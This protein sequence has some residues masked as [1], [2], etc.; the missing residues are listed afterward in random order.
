M[1]KILYFYS[2]EHCL[3][4]VIKFQGTLNSF[5]F[6]FLS[7]RNILIIICHILTVFANAAICKESKKLAGVCNQISLFRFFPRF[8]DS[9]W[10]TFCCW[11]FY[12]HDVAIIANFGY[13]VKN[14]IK[15]SS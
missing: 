4:S 12:I 14:S 7:A 9:T 11:I 6:F 10:V 3:H 15:L 2:A 8:I 5:L 1:K 13:F